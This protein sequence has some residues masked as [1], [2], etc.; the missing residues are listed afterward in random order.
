M[1]RNV[2]EISETNLSDT[3]YASI[4]L[5][6]YLLICDLVT[7]VLDEISLKILV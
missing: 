3:E 7:F 5:K 4:T 1:F 6:S 2:H